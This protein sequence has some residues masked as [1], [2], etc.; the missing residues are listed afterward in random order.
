MTSA[1]SRW[2]ASPVGAVTGGC[3]AQAELGAAGPASITSATPTHCPSVHRVGGS[4]CYAKIALV[5][6][7]GAA[8]T[9][10]FAKRNL[11]HG[12]QWRGAG[13]S[14]AQSLPE[15][16]AAAM[17]SLTQAAASAKDTCRACPSARLASC[18]PKPSLCLFASRLRCFLVSFLRP[19][20]PLAPIDNGP[21]WALACQR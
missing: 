21:A 20:T 12:S 18:L 1:F 14:M 2:R 4:R 8:E 16:R 17:C 6:L 3:I 5:I 11:A 9:E 10:R 19:S 13:C 7:V 15:H